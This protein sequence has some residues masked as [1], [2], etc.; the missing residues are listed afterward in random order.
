MQRRDFLNDL[1]MY[2]ALCT[3]L[4]S[5]WR[6]TARPR[7]AGDPFMLGVASGDPTPTGAVIWTRLAPSPLEPDGGMDRQRTV[8]SWEVAEDEQ[9]GR[10][11]RQGRAT[12]AP[13]LGYS[14]HADVDGLA[15]D[16]WYFYRFTVQNGSS[17][18]GR[19]RTAP[20]PG[21]MTSLAFG[22]VSCQHWEQ[23]YYT[24]YDHLAR[25]DRLDLIT[26]LGDY[27]YE[28]TGVDGRPRKYSS[29]EVLTLDDYRSRYAQTKTDPLLQAAHARAPWIVTW[30]DHE[31]DNNYADLIGENEMESE[32]QMRVRRAAGYQAWWEHQ[33]VRVPR[34]RNWGDLNIT[35]R[36]EWGGLTSFHVLDTR[37]H[38]SDQPCGDRGQTV[39][40][41][42][43]GD[44]THTMMGARQEQWLDDGMAASR[45]R[46][47]V[48]ANQ[49]RVMPFDDNPGPE[50]Q[51]YMDSWAGYPAAIDR[52]MKTI[53]QRAPNRTVVLTGDIHSNWVNTLHT[54]YDR[55][56][57]P[58][59][60]AEFVGT[61]I[62]SGGD[63]ADAF[64]SWNDL[65]RAANPQCIWHNGRRGYVM[66]AVDADEWRT[67]YRT[68]SYVSRLGAP[69]ETPAE[70]VLRHGRPGVNKVS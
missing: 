58:T 51:Y 60:A 42:N 39:P 50:R 70:F 47:Q 30:D 16:R 43:W 62:S 36:V 29:R 19:L 4:P 38:R 9:F 28:S 44:P 49:V 37:Q 7:V 35:R 31:V 5:A 24:A 41:G 65:T 63:G 17:P 59:I 15:S 11:V 10:V 34:V 45:A 52:L 23:G 67:T 22:F 27:I 68:V 46:W 3:G 6:V 40:C 48:L 12:A 57:A 66:C 56:D 53:G 20:A 33:P 61:S 55:P 8:V 13:E 25:E 1:A 2:S 69:V 54:R 14:I 26:H 32:D 18:V 21:A 64:G